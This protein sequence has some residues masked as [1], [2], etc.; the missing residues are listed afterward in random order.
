M[1]RA[2]FFDIDET[3]MQKEKFLMTN[4][5]RRLTLKNLFP[6]ESYSE[7]E[8]IRKLEKNLI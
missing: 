5:S 8:N 1:K 6:K 7:V 2:S 3:L 4:F